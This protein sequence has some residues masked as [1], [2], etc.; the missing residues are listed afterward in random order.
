MEWTRRA[1]GPGSAGHPARQRAVRGLRR[2]RLI[3]DHPEIARYLRGTSAACAVI[4]ITYGAHDGHDAPT[5]PSWPTRAR[6]RAATGRDLPTDPGELRARDRRAPGRPARAACRWSCWA[7]RGRDAYHRRGASTAASDEVVFLG[8]HPRP[9]PTSARCAS[10]PPSTSMATPSAAPTRR[11]SRRWRPA[12][13]LSPTTTCTTPGWPA[14]GSA[15]F[16]DE[17][18]LER[19]ST[20][21]S[22]DAAALARDGRSQ[23]R[24]V[25]RPSSP[26]STIGTQYEQALQSCAAALDQLDIAPGTE[27]ERQFSVIDVAVV[28]LGRWACPTCP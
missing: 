7:V 19:T 14:T 12:T 2:R 3:A 6:P 9:R 28:G 24:A 8:R 18:E 15:H 16:T 11:W 4:T 5:A 21:C 20:R 25:R 23:P 13:R 10:T 27:T 22:T 1:L 17:A 26:G